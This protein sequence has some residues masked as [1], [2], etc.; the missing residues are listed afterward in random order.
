MKY[1]KRSNDDIY[2]LEDDVVP[3]WDDAVEVTY[4]QSV[5]IIS[6]Q[7]QTEF[8]K[9]T[10]AEKRLA[11]YPPVTDYLDGVV[12]GDQAQIDAYIAACQAVKAKYPK[13]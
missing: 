5:E 9:L 4:E 7:S 3:R 10:Y 13:S 8:D 11:E 6:A 2:A 12:K 1:Y